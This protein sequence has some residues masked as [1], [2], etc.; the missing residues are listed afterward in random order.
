MSDVLDLLLLHLDDLKVQHKAGIN[1]GPD[2]IEKLFELHADA[3]RHKAETAGRGGDLHLHMSIDGR[4]FAEA[5]V[6]HLPA[7]P[8]TDRAIRPHE[9]EHPDPREQAVEHREPIG[10]PS[11]EPEPAPHRPNGNKPKG[12]PARRKAVRA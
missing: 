3:K 4:R 10:F 8:I 2:E 9:L 12:K 6:P 5:I 1:P 7:P 11:G